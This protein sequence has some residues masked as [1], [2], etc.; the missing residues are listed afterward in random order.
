MSH[1]ASLTP[2][3]PDLEALLAHERQRPGLSSAAQ[4]RIFE[5]LEHAPQP[6]PRRRF[7]ST[8]GSFILG[9]LVGGALASAPWLGRLGP[10]QPKMLVLDPPAPPPPVIVTVQPAAVPAVHAP[11]LAPASTAAPRRAS[12]HGEHGS[13]SAPAVEV[14]DDRDTDLARERALIETAR[15]AL[16]RKQ[17]DSVDLLLRH[18]QQFPRGRLAEERESLL[19]QALLVA[20]R[21]DEARRRGEK[22]RARWPRSLLW[23]VVDAALRSIP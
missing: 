14:Q 10:A 22:F 16:S 1:D 5:R 17:P 9:L 23:P 7:P 13:G 11:S 20:G 6:P 3:P 15:T 19:V 21:I 2:L 12:A 4:D 18:A 8:L